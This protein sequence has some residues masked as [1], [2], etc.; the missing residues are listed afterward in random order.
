MSTA[1]HHALHHKNNQSKRNLEFP[2]NTKGQSERVSSF[3]GCNVFGLKQLE[4]CLPKPIFQEF[5]KQLD[6]GVALKK[7]I[8][9]AV[10]HAVKV[11]AMD[12]G[13][14]HFTHWFQPQTDSTAEKHDSFLTL[15]YKAAGARF[16]VSFGNSI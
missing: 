2:K 15:G 11:W 4:Q 3:F 5:Q 10:A 7:Q 14:T 9:D 12:K 13:A 1:R 6:E 16:E 8:A